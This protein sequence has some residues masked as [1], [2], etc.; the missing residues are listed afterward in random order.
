MNPN[1]NIMRVVPVLLAAL[2]L[3]AIGCGG[4][5][6]NKKFATHQDLNKSG[7]LAEGWIPDC[8]PNNS[9]EIL[10]S[11]D[12]RTK[13][14]WVTFQTDR[15][16]IGEFLG[17]LKL[18]SDQK[19]ASDLSKD[20]RAPYWWPK[21]VRGSLWVLHCVDDKAGAPWYASVDGENFQVYMWRPNNP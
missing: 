7:Y 11:H 6:Q 13:S 17:W 16:G 9:K 8:L 20:P 19:A 18:A 15:D 3:T 2:I 5:L 21:A 4:G 1:Q 12:A 10:E 14:G